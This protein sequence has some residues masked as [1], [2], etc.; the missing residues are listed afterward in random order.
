MQEAGADRISD[1]HRTWLPLFFNN[2]GEKRSSG[3][4]F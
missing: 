3:N 2:R 4:T 1:G